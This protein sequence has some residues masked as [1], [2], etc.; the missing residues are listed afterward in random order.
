[1]NMQFPFSA[2]RAGLKKPRANVALRILLMT[3]GLVVFSAAMLG[4]IYALFVHDIG[5][6]ILDTGLAAGVFTATAGIVVFLSGRFS[7]RVKE[8]E[9]VVA[10]GYAIM[11]TGFFGY[12][13]VQSVAELLIVQ[14]I[15][16]FGQA[17]CS[18]SFDALYSKHVDPGKSG[19]QWGAWESMNYF[20]AAFG[21]LAGSTVA[22][23]FGFP[24]LF[25]VMGCL[26]YTS[27]LY[28]YFLPRKLL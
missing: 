19:T 25:V 26:A 15:I 11:A 7:D 18:P 13:V 27:A 1:M 8:A 5:G 16:G 22:S 4:P 17:L 3:D 6:D 23:L 12:L 2:K 24:A 28:I 21:A 9:I 20:A 10:S 14:V